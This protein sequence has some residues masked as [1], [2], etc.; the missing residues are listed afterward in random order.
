MDGLALGKL[1]PGLVCKKEDG[2]RKVI[3]MGNFRVH[4]AR[5]DGDNA[6]NL[7]ERPDTGF[8]TVPSAESGEEL[9]LTHEISA[10]RL[11]AYAER[12]APEDLEVG[13]R[14]EMKTSENYLGTMWWCWG[15]L[16]GDL[17]GKKLHSFSEGFCMAGNEERP[18]DEEVDKEGWVTGEDVSKL[19]FR[20]VEGGNGC[21]VEIVA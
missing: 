15:G 21:S 20:F 6:T 12:I 4:R 14:Y 9:V 18:S 3:S 19:V 2:S 5:Q 7:L 11:F 13:E 8:V 16:E 1:G 10:E 17:K